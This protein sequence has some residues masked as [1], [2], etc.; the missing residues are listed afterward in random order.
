MPTI[1]WRCARCPLI[2]REIYCSA[3]WQNFQI[4]SQQINFEEVCFA[5]NGW[6]LNI[7]TTAKALSKHIMRA[8]YITGHVW[9]QNFQL[10][11]FY[12]HTLTSDWTNLPKASHV[13]WEL[14]KYKCKLKKTIGVDA[15]ASVLTC[16]VEIGH[17][18]V[19]KRR[20]VTPV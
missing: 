6:F 20:Q 19:T 4:H 13:V 14:V 1:T 17:V 3:L 9:S 5:K 15:N 11:K 10:F 7:P 12:Y 2:S 18:S 16:H 8:S